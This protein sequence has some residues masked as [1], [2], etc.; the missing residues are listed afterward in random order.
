MMT[1]KLIPLKDMDT[2]GRDERTWDIRT[3]AF[4]LAIAAEISRRLK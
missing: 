4:W 2:G 3:W 1:K